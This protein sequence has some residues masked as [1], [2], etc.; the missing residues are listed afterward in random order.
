MLHFASF[1]FLVDL[2]TG[3]QVGQ[4]GRDG[5]RFYC[6]FEQLTTICTKSQAKVFTDYLHQRLSKDG[7]ETLSASSVVHTLSNLKA[8]FDWLTAI[9]KRKVD[10]RALL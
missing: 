3:Q 1:Q 10:C 4:L 5:T 9:K 6:L 7:A 2:G 8:L